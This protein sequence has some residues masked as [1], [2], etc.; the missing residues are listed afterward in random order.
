MLGDRSVCRSV[1]RTQKQTS[2]T[3]GR[4]G[5][6]VN[7]YK[8]LT[9]GGDPDP[10]VD[11]ESLFHFLRLVGLRG[12]FLDICQHFS[13]NQR[14]ISTIPGE[15]T[16]ADKVM[17]PQHSGTHT[18]DI[19]IRTRVRINP[20]CRINPDPHPESWITFGWNFGVGGGLR[21]LSALI[22]SVFSPSC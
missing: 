9:F 1:V 3:L 5:Q 2:T 14:P 15:M 13:H 18:A 22:I 7:L 12:G 8:W 20:P 16:D 11:S 21:S 6:G 17:H 19:R 10:R 4:H